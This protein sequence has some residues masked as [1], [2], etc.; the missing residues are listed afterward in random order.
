MECIDMLMILSMIYLL[1]PL[2]IF[3]LRK[4]KY[5]DQLAHY[6]DIPQKV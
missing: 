6:R 2:R 3:K 4:E 1:F 5:A